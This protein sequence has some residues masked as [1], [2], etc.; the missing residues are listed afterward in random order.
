[1][2]RVP[3]PGRDCCSSQ[4]DL[5]GRSG[6]QTADCSQ[7]PLTTWLWVVGWGNALFNQFPGSDGRTVQDARPRQSFLGLAGLTV[8]FSGPRLPRDPAE[9]RVGAGLAAGPGSASNAW[10]LW[11]SHSTP[12]FS[13]LGEESRSRNKP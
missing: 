9:C 4:T 13:W 2:S 1:M 8:P 3:A 12:S 10:P 7:G 5:Q 6:R 11:A